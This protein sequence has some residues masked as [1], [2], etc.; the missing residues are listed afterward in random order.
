[1]NQETFRMKNLHPLNRRKKLGAGHQ[2][3][4]HI[5]NI[6]DHIY[7]R[8]NIVLAHIISGKYNL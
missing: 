3:H 8:K 7:K 5:V 4:L 2:R 6:S 1:M